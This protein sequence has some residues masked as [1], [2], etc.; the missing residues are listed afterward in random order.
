MDKQEQILKGD[1]HEMTLRQVSHICKEILDQDGDIESK[2]V[3]KNI[4]DYIFETY[5]KKVMIV[6]FLL[7]MVFFF[8]PFTHQIHLDASKEDG[9]SSIKISLSSFVI[10]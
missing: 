9:Q 4:I 8:I 2:D 6:H 1:D 10:T 3:I 7:Y 5:S